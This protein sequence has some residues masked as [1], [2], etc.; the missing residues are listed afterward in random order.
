MPNFNVYKIASFHL[1]AHLIARFQVAV[2]HLSFKA[3]VSPPP[4][5]GTNSKPYRPRRRVWLS[6]FPRSGPSCRRSGPSAW[7]WSAAVGCCPCPASQ[8]HMSPLPAGLRMTIHGRERGQTHAGGGTRR[9]ARASS[10]LLCRDSF[11]PSV[12]SLGLFGSLRK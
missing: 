8:S 10:N 1:K 12:T 5:P 4:T 11:T 3:L 6:W 7:R 9:G 2:N